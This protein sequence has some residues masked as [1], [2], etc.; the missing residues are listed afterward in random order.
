MR[1]VQLNF[2]FFFSCRAG[3]KEKVHRKA[4]KV[5][6]ASGGRPAG[7]GG[8]AL[9]DSGAYRLEGAGAACLPRRARR[10]RPD[11][12][13][14]KL[15]RSTAGES[16]SARRPSRIYSRRQLPHKS[17][18]AQRERGAHFAALFVSVSCDAHSAAGDWTRFRRRWGRCLFVWIGY[19]LLT[20]RRMRRPILFLISSS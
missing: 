17:R 10:K 19:L 20:A 16:I 13:K 1:G 4:G 6:S 7:C 18:P 3:H 9:C 15:R 2:A 5:M 14:N 11:K 12:N 8:C